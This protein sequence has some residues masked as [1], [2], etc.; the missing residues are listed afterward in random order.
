M[1]EP[2]MLQ[3]TMPRPDPASS[4]LMPLGLIGCDAFE[5]ALLP[6]MRE[7]METCRDPDHH[8]WN[9][10][11]HVAAERWGTR[12]GLPLAYG[13]AQIVQALTRVRGTQLEICDTADRVRADV[14]TRDERLL[15]L[16]LHQLRRNHIA[17]GQDFLLDLTDGEFD[18]ELME[19]ALAFGRRH[20]CGAA[21]EVRFDGGTGPHLRPV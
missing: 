6:L 21:R 9:R 11:Y 8:T 4:A 14:V 10:A 15:L 5:Q 17:A 7:V 20:S 19:L 16:L 2:E 3:N 1:T 18:A 13:L 12:T